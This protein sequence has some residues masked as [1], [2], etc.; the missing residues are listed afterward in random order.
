M[1][2]KKP[3]KIY[4]ML[5]EHE[6][7]FL[8]HYLKSLET[9]TSEQEKKDVLAHIFLQGQVAGVREEAKN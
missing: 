5:K 7:K 9:C 2:M 4:D 1:E 8:D 6:Q 3:P